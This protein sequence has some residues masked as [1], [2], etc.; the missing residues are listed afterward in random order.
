MTK[1]DRWIEQQNTHETP[2]PVDLSGYLTE[3]AANDLYLGK[4]EEASDSFRLGGAERIDVHLEGV[5]K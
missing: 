4:T 5:I 3:T 2:K 1:L